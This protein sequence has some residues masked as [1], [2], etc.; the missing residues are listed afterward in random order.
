MPNMKDIPLPETSNR[1]D[2]S[3]HGGWLLPTRH[4]NID[5]RRRTAIMG[6]LNITPDSFSD[7]GRYLDPEAAV[8]RGVE[9]AEEGADV[10]DIGGESTRPGARS[11]TTEE[12]LE[13]VLPVIRGLRRVLTLPLSIDTYKAEVARRALEE[14][15]DLVNDVSAL[16]FDP[17]MVSLVAKEQVPVVLMHMQGRP[18]DMQL[19]PRYQDVLS[20]V[21][22]FLRGRIETATEAGVDQTRILIDPGIGFGK[23]LDHNL[24]LLRSLP[25]LGSL[26]APLL[27]GPSRKTFIGRILNLDADQRLEGSLGA[28]VAASLGGANMLRVHDVRGTARAVRVADSIR[29]GCAAE[30]NTNVS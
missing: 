15:V 14:G 5:M 10:I 21:R 23:N 22:I 24:T 18:R 12:E 19:E 30:E 6:I 7:G 4:G 17:D 1:P 2:F 25:S 8:R 29:F 11:V 3:G 13:R 9:L 27:V 26:G 20:E 16:R 28:A